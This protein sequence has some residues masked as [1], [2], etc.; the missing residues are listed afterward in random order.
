MFRTYIGTPSGVYGLEGEELTY[1]GLEGQP[2]WA[3]YAF[4]GDEGK[5]PEQDTV[6][7][8]SYGEGV[9]RSTDGGATWAPASDG[10]TATALRTIRDDPAHEGGVICGTE[11]GRGFRSADGG[12]TWQEMEGIAEVPD[13]SDASSER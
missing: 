4:N 2:I 7:A 6:L 10:L 12:Q 1:L 9:F 5:G 3:V 8:G 13:S 11:P